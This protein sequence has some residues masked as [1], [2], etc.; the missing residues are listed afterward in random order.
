MTRGLHGAGVHH[1]AGQIETAFF[2]WG[3]KFQAEGKSSVVVG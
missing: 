1:G 2:H 3:K